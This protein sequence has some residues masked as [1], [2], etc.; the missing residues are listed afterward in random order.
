MD[1]QTKYYLINKIE[2]ENDKSILEEILL[3]S[4]SDQEFQKIIDIQSASTNLQNWKRFDSSKAWDNIQN[5]KSKSRL[6]ILK[7]AAI[8]VLL[9]SVGMSYFLLQNNNEYKAGNSNRHIVLQD[10]SDIILYPNAILK[11]SEDFNSS[12]REISLEGDA[13]FNVAKK[14]SPFIVNLDKGS[15]DVLGTVFYIDQ[16][17]IGF[18]VEL[19]SGNVNV[20]DDKGNN[21]KIVANE[22]AIVDNDI[23]VVKTVSDSGDRLSDLKLDNVTINESIDILNNI[24][25]KNIIELKE[26]DC[27]LGNKTIHT[28]VKNSSVRE[29]INGLKLIF[30][31]RVI[32]T[33][34]KFIISE[35]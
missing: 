13:Y 32:N 29:F 35:S 10:G 7:Y 20:V 28:T 1:K 12:T 33:K 19:I 16:N 27:G 4:E 26:K 22:T 23:K 17:D 14:N 9:L 3:T 21:T 5:E 18:K 25:G 31:I 2:D 8:V 15:V 11:V 30:D 6:S 34:G 24:Y